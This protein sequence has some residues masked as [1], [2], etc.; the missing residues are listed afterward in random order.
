MGTEVG[1]LCTLSS[2]SQPLLRS[3]VLRRRRLGR[4]SDPPTESCGQSR[5][6]REGET[7]HRK[8]DMAGGRGLQTCAGHLPPTSQGWAELCWAGSWEAGGGASP[9][10]EEGQDLCTTTKGLTM[11][12]TK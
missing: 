8:G 2:S 5:G 3:L 4:G 11:Q 9:V 6:S 1:Q 12:R 7:T 10:G